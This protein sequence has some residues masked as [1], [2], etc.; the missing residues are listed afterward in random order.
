MKRKSKVIPKEGRP[1]THALHKEGFRPQ[2]AF[3]ITSQL[4][5]SVREAQAGSG[6]SQSAECEHRL[7][8][9]FIEDDL[10]TQRYGPNGALM[11]VIADA[12]ETARILGETLCTGSNSDQEAV[13]LYS[14]IIEAVRL[15]LKW[16]DPASDGR[17]YNPRY[18]GDGALTWETLP[19]HAAWAAY[20]RA[21]N[22]QGSNDPA[23]R[24][25]AFKQI[26]AAYDRLRSRQ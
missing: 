7:A 21:S 16:H 26:T 3:T 14:A 15:T 2:L 24:L 4:M 22:N 20:A 11:S 5:D 9:T 23:E 6:R 17:I 19:H 13:N 12:A 25:A 18:V 10:M 8:R 1:R